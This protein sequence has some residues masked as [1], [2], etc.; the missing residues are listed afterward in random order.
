MNSDRALPGNPLAFIKHCV[1]QRK[2]RWT[3]HVNMR[4]RD[5]SISRQTILGSIDS[6]EIVEEYP[7]DKYLPSYLIYAKYQETVFHLLVAADVENDNV[8]MVTA[9]RPD[10]EEWD[11]GLKQRRSTG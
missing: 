6:Y 3:Y 4:L 1:A 11:A 7:E 10:P 8:R 9:Y 2:I 5:R